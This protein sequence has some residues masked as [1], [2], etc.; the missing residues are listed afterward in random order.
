[1]ACGRYDAGQILFDLD[2]STRSNQER[3]VDAEIPA[4]LAKRLVEDPV[5]STS[6]EWVH[7]VSGD[8]RPH[9]VEELAAGRP[10]RSNRALHMGS[11]LCDA[12]F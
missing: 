8:E 1:M 7:L 6:L 12:E 5:A 4:P 10:Q 3:T 9:C 2:T 11:A